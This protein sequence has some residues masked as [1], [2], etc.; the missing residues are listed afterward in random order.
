MAEADRLNYSHY[1]SENITE[2]RELIND[3]SLNRPITVDELNSCIKE[4]KNG[5]SSSFDLI[6]NEILK[7]LNVDMKTLIL[8][9]FN[10]CFD[11]GTYPWNASIIT[12]IHKK[13]DI[14][15]PDNYRAIS[16]GS[17]LGKLFSSVLLRRLIIFR[18]TNSPDPKNQLGFTKNAQTAD[19]LLTLRTIASKYKLGKQ[20]VYSV[21]V[22]FRKAFDSMCSRI[23]TS[24]YIINRF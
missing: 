4:L 17:C 10:H 1:N 23:I 20:P 2:D 14:R 22:D 12:P 6:S 11:S 15:D 21:F 13:G 9:L 24:I 7:N 19:H 5:K 8:K 16:V 18:N 3:S